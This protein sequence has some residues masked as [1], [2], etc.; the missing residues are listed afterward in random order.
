MSDDRKIML[1]LQEGFK[2]DSVRIS[3][4]DRLVHWLDHVKTRTQLGLAHTL[5]LNLPAGNDPVQVE[6]PGKDVRISIDP[7]RT[8]ALYW[9]VSVS[10]NGKAMYVKRSAEPFGYA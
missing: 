2:D 8:D 7:G 5:E 10:P 6:L 3:V 4:G 1:A 9:G